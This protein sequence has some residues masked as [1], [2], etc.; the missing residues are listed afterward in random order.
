MTG[1]EVDGTRT[2]TFLNL[3]GHGTLEWQAASDEAMRELIERKMREG[4]AFFVLEPRYGGIVPPLKV[5]VTDVD[6]AMSGRKVHLSDADFAAV[7]AGG[8]ATLRPTAERDGSVSRAERGLSQ[9]DG[10]RSRD[11]ALVARSHSLAVRAMVG[12]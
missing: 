12:G 6:R 10:T 11:P 4:F 1:N 2:L 3:D 9:G 5:A 8:V 7:V